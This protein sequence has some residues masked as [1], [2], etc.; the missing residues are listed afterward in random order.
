[1][2]SRTSNTARFIE[3]LDYRERF[4]EHIISFDELEICGWYLCAREQFMKCADS[5]MTVSA[6]S[7]MASVFDSYYR[8]GLG[9]K[10]DLYGGLEK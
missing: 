2:S 3:F 8:A 10:N 9:F 1:M 4:Q 6:T 7:V 5:D